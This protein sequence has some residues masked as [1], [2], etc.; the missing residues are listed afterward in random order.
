MKLA[1]SEISG[2]CIASFQAAGPPKAVGRYQRVNVSFSG[3]LAGDVSLL[4]CRGANYDVNDVRRKT[5]RAD[6][7]PMW[8]FGGGAVGHRLE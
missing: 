3:F 6:Y 8:L 7:S 1:V 4:P 5:G 2:L